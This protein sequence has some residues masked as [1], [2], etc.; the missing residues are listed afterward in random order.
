MPLPRFTTAALLFSACTGCFDT[1]LETL[2]PRERAASSSAGGSSEMGTTGSTTSST[3]Q[4]GSGGS[5]SS[6]EQEL[7]VD[8]FEDQ[9]T[10]A[11]NGFGWWYATNDTAGDQDFR[12]SE[13]SDRASSHWAANTSGIGFDIWGA[14]VGLDLTPGDGTFDASSFEA[15]RFWAKA[16]PQ[17]VTHISARLL[18][19]SESQFGLDIELQQQ[20]TRYTLVFDELEAA[21]GSSRTLDA[22]RL[23]ALQLFVFSPERFDFW[24]DDVVLVPR[25]Q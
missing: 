21:D 7:L 20:W 2:V 1:E 16:G 11:A 9:D 17:S 4:D 14:L 18:E 3:T 8:D 6:P 15:M 22:S 25:L 24:I 10:R 12:I 23:A 19:S 13:I 5:V